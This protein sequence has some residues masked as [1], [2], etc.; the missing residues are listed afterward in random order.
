M[1]LSPA[2]IKMI[3]SKMKRLEWFTTFFPYASMELFSRRSIAANSELV[4]D[5]MDVLVTCK[6]KEDPIKNESA[7]RVV[8]IFSPL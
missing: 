7:R 3:Q 8:T 6:N 2:K 4:L 5:V 1:S